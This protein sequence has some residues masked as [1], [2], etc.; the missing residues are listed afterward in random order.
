MNRIKGLAIGLA[1]KVCSRKPETDSAPPSST[2]ATMRGRRMS[3][4]TAAFSPL[5]NSRVCTISL[6]DISR[7][8]ERMF[9]TSK[10]SSSAAN[11]PK[12]MR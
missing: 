2:T 11:M 5:R 1:K 3:Q 7:L 6:T 12:D 4:M 10:A 8:P 9:Q